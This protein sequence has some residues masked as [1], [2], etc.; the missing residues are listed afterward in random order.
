MKKFNMNNSIIKII[1][2]RGFWKTK[3]EMNSRRAFSNAIRNNYGIETD[4]RDFRGKIVIS[5]DILSGGKILT[6]DEFIY[7]Y[8]SDCTK[9]NS[10]TTLALNIK[11]DGLF[12][13]IS[14]V[15]KKYHIDNYFLFDM[16]F[17]ESMNYKSLNLNIFYRMSEYENISRNVKNIK[18]V[19]LDQ[20][21]SNW[22]NKKKI[23][24]IRDKW[25]EICVVSP[26][27]HKRD[28]LECWSILKYLKNK[29]KI[30]LCTDFPDKA[31]EFF[32]G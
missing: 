13:K 27:L 28:Y 10:D 3:K 15:L 24:E 18:G 8:K 16:S 2:H 19:W 12:N 1:S 9:Y 21:K 32:N 26:E 22:Y 4:V 23:N 31:E 11:S 17:P 20:F 5:H 6:F 29:K 30:M 14:K 25:G 7:K